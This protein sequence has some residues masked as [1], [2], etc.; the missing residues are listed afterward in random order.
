M[1][2]MQLING[3]ILLIHLY[4][5]VKISSK[6]TK[7]IIRILTD[8]ANN[9]TEPINPLTK[10]CSEFSDCFN[11]TI[12][13]KCRWIWESRECVPFE[14]FIEKYSIPILNKNRENNNIVTINNH[15]DFIRKSC[16]MHLRPYM[17]NSNNYYNFFIKYCGPHYIVNDED[18]I[19]QF[20]LEIQK[21]NGVYGTPNLICEFIILSGP[22]FYVNI[23][24]DEKEKNNFYLLYSDDSLNFKSIIDSPTKIYLQTDNKYLNTFVFYGFKSFKKSPFVIEYKEDLMEKAKKALGYIMVALSCL[25]IIII[26]TAIILIRK[27][28]KFFRKNEKNF[29]DD[30]I[31]KLKKLHKKKNGQDILNEKLSSEETKLKEKKANGCG[32]DFSPKSSSRY[33]GQEFSYDNICCVDLKII[34]NK[35]EIKIANCGHYYH[36]FCFNRLIKEMKNSNKK[37]IKCISCKKI[38]YP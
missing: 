10:Y 26:F 31:E 11:C 12:F 20:R 38:I 6:N 36:V 33:N 13:P 22:N 17:D 8:I 23:E 19:N 27:R 18:N 14:P 15:I 21:I 29:I 1:K 4:I 25:M 30:E 9:P 7:N 28:A 5:I 24:I 16:F 3:Q 2:L 37:E 34:E 35:E 32:Y